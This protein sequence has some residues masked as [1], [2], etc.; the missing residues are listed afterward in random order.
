M[1]KKVVIEKLE[2]LG[3]SELNSR[4]FDNAFSVFNNPNRKLII[5]GF[6]GSDTDLIWTNKSA[7]EYG[8]DN[9][10]DF[11]VANGAEGEWLSKTLPKRLLSLPLD[12]GFTLKETVYTNA[13]LLC[14]K[15]AYAIKKK[16]KE[17]GFKHVNEVVEK[18]MTF[19]E[20]VTVGD[21]TPELIICYSNGMNDLS[22][23]SV[24]FNRFGVSEIAIAND[25]NYYKTFS[26]IANINNHFVPV[27][28][29][30]H[31]SRFKPC[32]DSIKKAWKYEMERISLIQR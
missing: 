17:V 9:P 27:I 24:L 18:S 15:D 12:L 1:N 30:R 20:Q 10:D 22:A 3:L 2:E 19:L 29:I 13:I 21:S 5:V 28:G 26:F 7:V 23:S 8:F 16:A 25:N 4:P 6:N 11:N 32:I 31:M 14:S